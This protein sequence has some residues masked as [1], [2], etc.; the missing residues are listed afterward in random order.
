MSNLFPTGDSLGMNSVQR[1]FIAA[2]ALIIEDG[3]TT[4]SMSG[5]TFGNDEFL[6]YVYIGRNLEITSV[7]GFGNV[8]SYLM[9]DELS[10]GPNVTRIGNSS[11]TFYDFY[12]TT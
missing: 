5:I 1:L 9:L 11:G 10:F 6:R 7:S 2:T 12:N 4:L 8:F 3:T